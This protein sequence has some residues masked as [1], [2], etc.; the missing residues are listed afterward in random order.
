MDRSK[1]QTSDFLFVL[2]AGGCALLAYSLVYALRKSFT[3]STFDGY[4]LWGIDY[5]IAISI[6]QIA[7]YLLSKFAGIKIVSEL[8]RKD[9][10]KAII[11][12]AIS[13]ETSLILFGLVPID[14]K[15]ICL[16]LNGLS[17]GTMWGFLF[18]YLE[19]RR[20]TD[21]LAGLLGVSI[22]ISSGAAKS[23][24]LY[25]LSLGID[26]FW[27]PALIG[28][29]AMFLLILTA[30]V[31]DKIPDPTPE[32]KALKTERVSLN[33]QQR[34]ELL[35]QYGFLLFPLLLVNIL[36]TVLRDIKEDF[37]VDILSH[38]NIHLTN[39]LFVRI[40]LV[41]T[42]L[43]LC[44][45]ASMSYVKDN[46]KAIYILLQL[47]M[48]ASALV[49]LSS[50]FFDSFENIPILWLFLQSLGIYTAYLAFQTIFFDRFIAHY[51]ISGNVGF[52]IYLAD[53]L[54]YFFSCLFL[55]G[56]SFFHMH[57]NWLKY[58]NIL[59]VSMSIVC[60]MAIAIT[61]ICIKIKREKINIK[62]IQLCDITEK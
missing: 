36:Y 18:S 41:V 12:S 49:F 48:A 52:F 10:L 24:G 60:L 11:I 9:R 2:W 45:F 57:I 38:T 15:F 43:L 40:D 58:Y 5:K 6:S 23:V 35:K 19:G 20:L 26:P 51:R 30:A 25:V 4:E 47:M 14:L 53:F 31:L 33:R 56:K 50:V 13:A 3:A 28:G 7:G 34:F 59:S 16:F 54:G 29:I 27:M 32:E 61:Y 55:I 42:L 37:L 17:I 62:K 46:K 21:I 22:V 39:F 8:K 1:R 44:M